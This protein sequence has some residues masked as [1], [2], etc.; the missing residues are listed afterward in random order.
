MAPRL[1]NQAMGLPSKSTTTWDAYPRNFRGAVLRNAHGCALTA[2]RLTVDQDMSCDARFQADGEVGLM[3][4]HISG[5]LSFKG[6]TLRNRGGH[7]LVAGGLN[8]G[9]DMLCEGA[10]WVLG[11][12]GLIG[13]H[14]SGML[15][16]RGAR[17]YSPGGL[18]LA[19]DGLTVDQIMLCEQ[20]FR[21]YGE[22]RLVGAHIRGALSFNGATLRNPG[23]LA[24]NANRLAVDHYMLCRELQAKGEIS[25]LGVHISGALHFRGASLH[26]PGGL[27]LNAN[28]LIVDE[29]LHW[30]DGFYAAGAVQLRDARL[31][32]LYDSKDT[33][34]AQLLLDGLT[35]SRLVDVR[36]VS[37]KPQPKQRLGWLRRSPVGYT[38]Q[39]YEQLAAVYRRA[40]QPEA[41][42]KVLIAK[43]WDRR[44]TLHPLGKPL[45]WLAYLTV[46]YGYRTGRAGLWLAVLGGVGPQVFNHAYQ[47]GLLTP[48]RDK[49]Q[50]PPFHAVGYAWDVLLPIINL[51]QESAWIPHGWAVR[52]TYGFILAGWVLTT[53]VVAGLTGVLKR[54]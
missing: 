47:I 19:A 43:Q 4:A 10:F 22:V 48:A 2:D 53:A 39:P 26:N 29:D 15:D 13:A 38:P 51:G 27:A 44:S 35:Y 31:G 12:V 20:G 32:G 1:A 7:A 25:L 28:R 16:F 52:C 37:T 41:A 5:T 8:I 30:E 11:D 18:A 23:G 46:G 21:A 24:L 9:G 34:P 40:G 45:N 14:I 42:R 17:L 50:Q 49:A 54:D 36:Q 3:G 33:W 6:A